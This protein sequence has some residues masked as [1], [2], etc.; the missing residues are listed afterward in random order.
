MLLDLDPAIN[1]N[2]KQMTQIHLVKMIKYHFGIYLPNNGDSSGHS[3]FSVEIFDW[4]GAAVHDLSFPFSSFSLTIVCVA[5]KLTLIVL[6][7][8]P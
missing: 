4:R 7:V 3:S 5:S 8:S 2:Q 1:T 6:S